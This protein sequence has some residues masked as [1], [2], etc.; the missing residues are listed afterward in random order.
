MKIWYC[1]LLS[2]FTLPGFAQKYDGMVICYQDTFIVKPDPRRV[3]SGTHT[4]DSFRAVHCEKRSNVGMGVHFGFAHYHY[5][6]KT[7]AWIGNHGS[8]FFNL[9]L[10][11]DKFNLGFRFKPWTIQPGTPLVFNKD[12][13]PDIAKVNAVKI[14]YYLGYSVDFNKGVSLEPYLG[15]S[16]TLFS[17]INEDELKK[18]YS[19]PKAAG[20]SAGV[21]FHKYFKG[22]QYQYFDLQA[23]AGYSL[24]NYTKVN[25]TL[26]K[27]YFEWTI[28]IGYKAFLIEQFNQRVN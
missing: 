12:T 20:P 22:K 7:K 25:P 14:D 17:V 10:A 28:G 11:Y 5:N 21:T 27:G 18:T 3:I 16:N 9:L 8:G 26:G 23:S 19:L 2:L 24:T 13:L 4:P 6:G 15:L 1:I